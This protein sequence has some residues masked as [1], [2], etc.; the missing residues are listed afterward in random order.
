M[1][2]ITLIVNGMER[3]FRDDYHVLHNNDWSEVVREM[4]DDTRVK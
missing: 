1:M 4:L 2:E 3:V